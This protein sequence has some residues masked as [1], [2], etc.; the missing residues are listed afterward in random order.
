MKDIDEWHKI[1]DELTSMFKICGCQRK[2][3][4][5]IDNLYDIYIKLQAKE[6][7]FTGAEWLLLALI[8]KHFPSNLC[9]G[10]NCEYPIILEDGILWQFILRVKDNP[11][12]EDN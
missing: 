7:N 5:I 2:L 12:L 3:K 10:I 11:C 9:H 4:T 1:G 6:F 8:D